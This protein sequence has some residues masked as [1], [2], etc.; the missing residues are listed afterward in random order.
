MDRFPIQATLERAA[1][2]LDVDG[3]LL[4][5]APRPDAVICPPEL[6]SLL[7]TLAT[8]TQGAVALITG[9]EIAFIDHI[10]PELGLP[11][12]GLHGAE[13]RDENGIINR[14][15]PDQNFLIAKEFIRQEAIGFPDVIFEDKNASVALHYRHAPSFENHVKACLLKAAKIAG[16]DWQIQYGKMVAEL[17]PSGCDKG[18]A[19][20]YF[21]Q[22][23][24]FK[25]RLPYA[26]GDDLTD[27]NMFTVCA[28][29][30][31]AGIFIG[32]QNNNTSATFFIAS[33]DRL[34][35]F[36]KHILEQPKGS[37]IFRD[38]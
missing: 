23:A 11:I 30:A 14:R 37:H 16:S 21:M 4:D 25:D 19:I 1:F 26:F 22:S 3:T 17:R 13:I 15:D 33:P 2:F 5:I 12:A 35:S 36:L 32:E 6:P 27:E 31:G 20:E 38:L 18:S 29:Y 10:L 7:R 8:R 9:R 24:P 34:R 28:R